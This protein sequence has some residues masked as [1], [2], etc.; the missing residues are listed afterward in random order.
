MNYKLNENKFQ[1]FVHIRFAV[2]ARTESPSIIESYTTTADEVIEDRESRKSEV[3]TTMDFAA[4]IEKVKE[5]KQNIK[6]P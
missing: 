2:T 3:Q 1:T 4:N 6:Q 5:V